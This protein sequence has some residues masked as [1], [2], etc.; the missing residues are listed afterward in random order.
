MTVISDDIMRSQQRS[1]S[2]AF[3]EHSIER[4]L[5]GRKDNSAQIAFAFYTIA[6]AAK[7]AKIDAGAFS[8]TAAEIDSFK[9]I[10]T[11]A[12]K[13]EIDVS[14]YYNAAISDNV[15]ATHYAK[16]LVNLFPSNRILLEEFVDDLLNFADADSQMSS[17]KVMFLRD[18]TLALNFDENFFKDRL[19]KHILHNHQD[20]FLLLN[21]DKN[22]SFVDLKKQY[23]NAAKDWH[24]DRFLN[25]N[26]D[27]LLAQIA[28]EQFDI[29]TKAF[30]AIKAARGF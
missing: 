14:L 4:K 12:C 8:T 26:I 19:S 2:I 11:V 3:R 28:R 24:P 16:Q 25:K 22:V 15:Q 30:D 5:S 23:R 10:F 13:A 7:L 1:K 17:P 6:I 21:V 20:P 9:E 29:Y 27:P 18:V